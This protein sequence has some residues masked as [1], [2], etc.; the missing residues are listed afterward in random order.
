MSHKLPILQDEIK[1][2]LPHRDPMLF[3]DRVIALDEDNIVIESDIS[4]F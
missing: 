2:Y 1:T 4:L 3:I